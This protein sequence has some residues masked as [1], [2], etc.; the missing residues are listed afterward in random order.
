MVLESIRTP[1]A[2][3]THAYI[4][5]IYKDTMEGPTTYSPNLPATLRATINLPSSKSI[6]NRALLLCALS[7]P[8][9]SVERMSNCDDTFVMWRA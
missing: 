2:L 1:P 9:S 5:Y 3:P 8:D 4:Y 6:S 7:G